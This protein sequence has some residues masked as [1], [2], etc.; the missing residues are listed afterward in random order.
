MSAVPA[1]QLRAV[2][3]RFGTDAPVLAD[4]DL[5]VAPG[6][7]VSLLG[8]SGCGKSTLLRL[9]SGLSPTTEGEVRLL[10][11]SPEATR[12][13]LAY[14]FQDATLLPWL[15]IAGNIEAPLRLRGMAR[16]ERRRRAAE[17]LE[18]VRLRDVATRHPRQLSGG[19]KMRVSVARALAL[20]PEVL[21]LDE[22]FGALDEM[23][24]QRLNEELLQL[25]EHH[26]WAAIFVT[27]SVAEAVFLS[28]RVLVLGGRPGRIAAEF[29]IPFPQPRRAEL[30]ATR[31]FHEYV[32]QVSAALR[33]A[34]GEGGT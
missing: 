13:R 9:V 15:T 31:E 16:E 18:L 3:K 29:A 2:T 25:R 5:A 27:H 23:T 1:V 19:M 14:I 10:G 11:G 33:A 8:P 32:V 24:R 30:R 34:E 6:E 17:V 7:F 21:L 4:L 22:P 28:H 26:A 12:G 20:E